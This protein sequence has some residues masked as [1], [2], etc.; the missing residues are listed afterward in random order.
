MHLKSTEHQVVAKRRSRQRESSTWLEW[1]ARFNC[2]ISSSLT[3]MK[4]SDIFHLKF[5]CGCEAC[6]LTTHVYRKLNN[7]V[8]KMLSRIMGQCIAEEPRTTSANTVM[9]E[10]LPVELAWPHTARGRG[11]IRTSCTSEMR[12][13]REEITAW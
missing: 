10:R 3:R 1:T 7:T 12:Q 9:Y 11:K 4:T 2:L 6:K 8:F 13:A 5:P